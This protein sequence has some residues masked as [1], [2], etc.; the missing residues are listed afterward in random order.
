MLK[1]E[2]NFL[3]MTKSVH[4][5][6][7]S[8][9]SSSSPFLPPAFRFITILK[10]WYF[11]IFFLFPL[12]LHF[13][14]FCL[15]FLNFLLLIQQFF[16][17][18]PMKLKGLRAGLLSIW[19]SGFL[20]IALSFYGTQLLSPTSL[21][22][23]F[24][25]S[26]DSIATAAPRITIFTSLNVSSLEENSQALLALRSWLALSSQ[27]TVVLFTQH[28]N[29]N[30]NNNNNHSSDSSS[31]TDKFGSRLLL[32]S[33]IDFTFLGTPFLHSMMSRIEAYQSDIAVLMDPET[34]LLPDFISA[35]SYAHEL[36]RDWLL[37]SSS[38]EIP[39]FPFHWDETR[40]FW[41]QDNGKRVRFRELQKMISLRSLQSNSSASKMIMAWNN[42]DMPLHCGVLPPFLYQRGNAENI[43][44]RS[45]NVSEPKTRNWEY[46]GNSHLGQLYGSLYSRSYTLPKLLKC[47]RR[48]IFVSAS[49]R[50]T[51]LSIPKGKSLGFRTREKISACITRTKSRSLKLDFVQKD[52]TVPPLKFPF[53]LESLLPLVA[54]KNR[55]VV[56]S[57]A[58][59]SYKDMLM[60]WVCRLRRLKVPNFLVCALDD[61]T[62]QFSILQGL[63]VFFDPYAPK[64]ISFNDC[65]F[66][67]KC[68]QRVTKVKSRTVLK[69]LKLGY[70]VLLSDVDVYWFRNPLPLL[71][72]FGPSVLAAQSDEYNT[73]APINRPRRLNSGFYFA[74]SDSPTIAAME[75]VVKHA[76]TSGLSEQ[77]SFYD[78][79]CGEGGAYRLGDDRCVEPETNLTV[80]FLDRE[81]F[82]NGAY[83]DLWLKEDVRAEC[84]KKHCFVLHNN[85]ISGR[86]KKLERQMMKGL[87][88]YDASMRMCV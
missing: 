54:D 12:K 25:Y 26:G 36:G 24:R 58:G 34:V 52:E 22:D 6:S 27:I 66:G 48:Y 70:N 2:N 78:T 71:Q 11:S 82:P 28:N 44:N 60:S 63:P 64:N 51:D 49:E 7:S 35:L 4:M 10:F 72:S 86:L 50:S 40:H 16:F 41:R 13:F 23:P 42:I 80:Q 83:G 55:T 9:S 53:D 29:N 77:P 8:S 3:K 84:E 76:A 73:T 14:N 32:D 38:V 79:L 57:V 21:N 39:R 1:S 87:W 81:L 47:N 17:R 46:V 69:I 30:N 75:K 62:Y 61:E 65:H 5:S 31:F 56:L 37:V 68:F 59:Y 43:Y 18:F 88:E 67:S 33:T 74:R 15:Y 19:L 85:W 45:D 20:L